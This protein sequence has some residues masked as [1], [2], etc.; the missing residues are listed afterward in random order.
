MNIET[1]TENDLE[2]ILKIYA[3]ARAFMK[4][5]GN[6]DQWGDGHPPRELIERDIAQGKSYV[7]RENGQIAAVFYCAV[8]NDPTY[9]V[10]EGAWLND[11]PYA[12]IHRLASAKTVRGAAQACLLWAAEKFQNVRIDTHENNL[13]M[14]N[15]LKKTGFFRC[16]RI[17]LEN[18]DERIAYQRTSL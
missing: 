15:L 6:P 4:S 17:W 2:E 14:Q 12:V 18:G 8:E 7:C 11:K 9:A 16:G 3:D 5:H 13:P 10:I 1:A